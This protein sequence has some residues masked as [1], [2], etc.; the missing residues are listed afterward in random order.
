MDDF[1][2]KIQLGTFLLMMKDKIGDGLKEVVDEMI[3]VVEATLDKETDGE[4]DLAQIKST[5]MKN[6]EVYIDREI[7]GPIID[8]REPTEPAPATLTDQEEQRDEQA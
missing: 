6:L 8:E 1:A 5:M 7:L 4:V 3:K 2:N